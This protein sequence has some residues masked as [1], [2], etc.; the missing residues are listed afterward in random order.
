MRYCI[1]EEN[2]SS[3]F[4]QNLAKRKESIAMSSL[5]YT[6]L[7]HSAQICP[8]IRTRPVTWNYK[9]MDKIN[10]KSKLIDWTDSWLE[11][12]SETISLT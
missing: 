4:E 11:L 3:Q 9:E 7:N 6:D 10:F 12:K 1:Q 8:A 5:R 2:N